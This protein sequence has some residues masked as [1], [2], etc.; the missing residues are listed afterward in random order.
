MLAV[1]LIFNTLQLNNYFPTV[2]H[3]TTIESK[4]FSQA[5]TFK[6]RKLSK[7]KF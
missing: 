3:V 4:Q 7:I 6:N 2:L 1:T 5:Q